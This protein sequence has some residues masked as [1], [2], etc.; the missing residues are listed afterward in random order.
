[1]IPAA[2]KLPAEKLNVIAVAVVAVKF[3]FAAPA[4]GHSSLAGLLLVVMS[5]PVVEL[6]V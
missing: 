5:I 4:A 6:D 2:D 1:L 3:N